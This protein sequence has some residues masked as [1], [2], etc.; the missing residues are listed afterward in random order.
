MT[1]GTTS[2]PGGATP[3]SGGT[4]RLLVGIIAV[5][6]LAA[7]AVGFYF[8]GKSAADADAAEQRGEENG[9]S[10]EAA[11]YRP[12][13]PK[14]QAIYA[15]GRRAGARAGR[16]TGVRVGAEQGQKVGFTRGQKVGELQGDRQ[17]IQQ[18]ANAALGGISDWQVGS[19]YIVKFATGTDGVPYSIDSQKQMS[20]NERY[21]IC[22]DNP[23]DICTEPTASG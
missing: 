11:E 2:A 22:A 21:A 10:A 5:L 7:V 8:I 18:G 15:A 3:E 17:G 19:Y 23:A 13:T 1:N 9:R 16:R 20:P 4:N 12:G 14:Y 6:V